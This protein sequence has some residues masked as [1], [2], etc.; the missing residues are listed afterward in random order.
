[1]SLLPWNTELAAGSEADSWSRKG[2][3]AGRVER[4]DYS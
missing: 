2:G 1:M 4:I 3:Y